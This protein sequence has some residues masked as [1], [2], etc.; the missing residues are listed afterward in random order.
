MSQH[1]YG[2]YGGGGGGASRRRAPGINV[3]QEWTNNLRAGNAQPMTGG[4]KAK[5]Y[6]GAPPHSGRSPQG[7]A[8]NYVKQQVADLSSPHEAR[9]AARRHTR[10]GGV[11]QPD[12]S[13]KLEVLDPDELTAE[14]FSLKKSVLAHE[15]QR[16][17]LKTEIQRLERDNSK[18]EEIVKEQ[19]EEIA[20]PLAG[21]G[22]T[23]LQG[24]ASSDGR[25][26]SHL[27]VNLKQTIRGLRKELDATRAHGVEVET[28]L[29]FTDMEELSLVARANFEEVQRLQLLLQS[30]HGGDGNDDEGEEDFDLAG[31]GVK[32][33][34]QA[35]QRMDNEC[36]WLK[37]ENAEL[38]TDLTKAIEAGQILSGKL[39]APPVA[40]GDGKKY[41]TMQKPELVKKLLEEENRVVLLQAEIAGLREKCVAQDEAEDV[42]AR[43]VGLKSAK[44]AQELKQAVSALR[45]ENQRLLNDADAAIGSV[46]VARSHSGG[47]PKVASTGPI[48]VRAPGPSASGSQ[49]AAADPLSQSGAGADSTAGGL[50]S[51]IR[52]TNHV[53][54]ADPHDGSVVYQTYQPDDR[55][56]AAN[57]TRGTPD[58]LSMST[59][60]LRMSQVL[61]PPTVPDA[62]TATTSAG[63]RLEQKST[64]AANAKRKRWL[65]ENKGA[66]DVAITQIQSAI[67]GHAARR[68]IDTRIRAE[69][70]APL[71][72][73][74]RSTMEGEELD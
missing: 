68:V 57:R 73:S 23:T 44:E 9:T 55:D 70:D 15:T 54:E 71:S 29:R 18:L 59:D 49:R 32:P 48:R 3:R 27:V 41:E 40:P 13:S 42:A 21:G 72:A 7:S 30:G 67:R 37:E 10:R 47:S 12:W 60:T 14:I 74:L 24:T 58:D 52:K 34:A 6:P 39:R 69:K 11:R 17:L 33:T 53:G 31:T 38:Q 64:A 45:A 19:G 50:L 35:F 4:G 63:K 51:S 25:A 16:K 5:E 28:S 65:Q 61:E 1:S 56:D 8:T 46:A 20:G 2:M 26:N 36:R 66:V 62:Q 22:G 43:R